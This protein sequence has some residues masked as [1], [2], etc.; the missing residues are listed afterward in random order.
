[1][2]SKVDCEQLE[3]VPYSETLEISTVY[4]LL[5]VIKR[6]ACL[7]FLHQNQKNGQKVERMP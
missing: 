6:V 1:M 3:K 7:N 5:H 4:I 2:D